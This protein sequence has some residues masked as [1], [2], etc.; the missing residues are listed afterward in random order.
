MVGEI[1]RWKEYWKTKICDVGPNKVLIRGY[2][3]QELIGNLSYAEVLYLI[4][5]GELPDEKTAKVFEA[6]LL[7]VI[8]HG[9]LNAAT[10]TARFVVSGNPSI[11]AGIAAGILSIGFWTG[12]AQQY[13]AEFINEAY[14]LMKKENLTMEETA[15]KVVEK[16]L[17]EKKRIPGFGHPLHNPDPRAEQLYRVAE[18]YGKVG[19]KL[20]LYKAIHAEFVKQTGKNIPINCD[21]MMGAILTELGFDP[22]IMNAL[23][24]VCMLPGIIAHAYEELKEGTPVRILPGIITTYIGKPER[25][26]PEEKKKI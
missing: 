17:K 8:D 15:K 12:G 20:K 11:I 3:V 16:Y 7:T 10:P 9:F 13:T 22:E 25:H 21:G 1:D 26:L 18:K 14:N 2:P 5:K 19:E 24:A 6:T 23:A 4:L